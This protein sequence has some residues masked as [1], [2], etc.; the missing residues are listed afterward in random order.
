MPRNL[1]QLYQ[2]Q[3]EK[4]GV[5]FGDN[6]QEDLILLLVVPLVASSLLGL[7][8]R[9]LGFSVIA[10]YI[11]GGIIV[12]PLLHLVD[13]SSPIL[14]FL[15]ELGIILISFEI[16][17]VVK[18]DF[19]SRG[20]LRSG[21]IVAVEV[22]IISLVSIFLGTILNLPYG[23]IL[24]LVFIAANTSTAVTFK[25]LEERGINDQ[26]IRNTILGV[27]AFE[28]I[29][30]IIGLSV[31]PVLAAA[32]RPD[33][34]ELLKILGGIILS[35]IFMVYLGLRLLRNP[36][37]WAAGK[38]SEIFLALSLGVVLTY[39]YVGLLVGLST[40]FGAFIA[41]LVVSNLDVSEVVEDKIR[42]LRDLSSLIFFSSIG[43][44]LPLVQDPLLLAVAFI[45]TL[46]VVLIKYIGFSLSSW[47]M[48]V[49]LEESFR[50]GLYMLAISEFGVIIARN[51]AESGLASQNLYMVSVI[52][53]AGSAVMSSSFIMFEKTLPERLASAIP[54]K[55]REGM[56][57]LFHITGEALEKKQE[58]FSEIRSAFWELMRRF[59]IV[60]LVVGL[61]N[62]AL[63]YV[64]PNIR[65]VVVKLYVEIVVV[66]FTLLIV[67][68]ILLRM[69]RVYQKLIRGVLSRMEK[70]GKSVSDYMEGFL[71]AIT[72]A[73]IS[74]TVLLL[75]FPVIERSL[76][77]II[78][79]LGSSIL[80]LTTII[81]IVFFAG[82]SA[83]KAA[84]RLED[85]FEIE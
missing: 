60:L 70:P 53:L 31:F 76:N 43:A 78:G 66:G 12:G 85:T 73:I 50:L 83:L 11:I 63:T 51:A 8:A 42:S 82:R 62:I 36:L 14:S 15:S 26:G 44:S 17:L 35:V 5:R 32:G 22:F 28:D 57:S 64:T 55:M 29:L 20:G 4:R 9:R 34:I 71:Y 75:S 68:F 74:I 56:E 38:E 27:G 54:L 39:A 21:G 19:I 33:T 81:L 49:K 3:L 2:S 48:G 69:R 47:V 6:M 37:K 72:F 16:G 58:V 10:G 65:P 46:L 23:D 13:P 30:A 1:F 84:K 80:V 79:E 41:G 7:L 77:Y 61:S 25:M 67:I 52:A 59:A 24:V 18:L 45:V 40:A